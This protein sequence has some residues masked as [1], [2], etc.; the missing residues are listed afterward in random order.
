[1]ALSISHISYSTAPFILYLQESVTVNIEVKQTN[2]PPTFY[3]SHYFATIP[4][5]WEVGHVIIASI[6]AVDFDQV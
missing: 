5:D 6:E 4:E 1:M 2:F 3:S